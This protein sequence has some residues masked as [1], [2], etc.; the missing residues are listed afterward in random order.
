MYIDLPSNINWEPAAAWLTEHAEPVETHAKEVF[1]GGAMNAFRSP[2]GEALLRLLGPEV[3]AAVG[4][5]VYGSYSF[6]WIYPRGSWLAPHLDRENAHWLCSIPV[7]QDSAWSIW[8]DDGPWWREYPTRVGQAVILDGAKYAHARRAYDG[9]RSVNL[10]LSYDVRP[11]IAWRRQ[12]TAGITSPP[13]LSEFLSAAKEIGIEP[14]DYR[15]FRPRLEPRLVSMPIPVDIDLCRAVGAKVHRFAQGGATIFSNAASELLALQLAL[16]PTLGLNL[17][18]AE[19][20]GILFQTADDTFVR[21]ASPRDDLIV[22]LPL[23]EHSARWLVSD[24]GS[25]I[26]CPLGSGVLFGEY[27]MN[28]KWEAGDTPWSNWAVL[29]YKRVSEW[30]D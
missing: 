29:P 19:A 3:S 17:V 20:V 30:H 15:G 28:I 21:P 26:Q 25:P 12:Q 11:E 1:G 7:E 13:P 6:G 9:E 10:I 4:E 18:C 27:P 14:S 8:V 2:Y 5:T 22:A 16:R 23:D 24:G